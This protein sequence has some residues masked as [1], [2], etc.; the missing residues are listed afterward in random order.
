MVELGLKEAGKNKVM[1]VGTPL[2]EIA[3]ERIFAQTA[4]T[5]NRQMLAKSEL[6]V[7]ALTAEV[8]LL[9]NSVLETGTGEIA[10]SHEEGFHKL[11]LR[12]DEL[13]TQQLLGLDVLDIQDASERANRKKL[14]KLVSV[15]HATIDELKK[16]IA[17]KVPH[18]SSDGP[19]PA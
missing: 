10:K 1:V 12:L 3:T 5:K 9:R 18:C 8:S 17:E 14:I 2:K 15:Q 7:E 4:G 13:L 6:Q 19:A 11:I 16:C